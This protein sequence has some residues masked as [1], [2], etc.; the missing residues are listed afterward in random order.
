[1][2]HPCLATLCVLLVFVVG[3][4]CV[5]SQT[6]TVELQ[7][8]DKDG[9]IGQLLAQQLPREHFSK[10]PFDETI[11]KRAFD[12]YLKSL[13]PQ[14]YYF[15]QS[16]IDEFK[17]DETEI[18]NQLTSG[19]VDLGFEIYNRFVQRFDERTMMVGE[20]LKSPLDLS[21]HEE[22]IIDKNLLTYP[23]TKEEA[24]DRCRKKVKY[25]YLTLN[26]D[27]RDALEMKNGGTQT[28]STTEARIARLQRRNE[29]TKKRVHL[30]N[31]YDVLELYLSAVA[32]AYDPYSSYMPEDLF[33]STA[34]VWLDGIG[35]SL[36]LEDGIATI[37]QIITAGPA[38]KD[39]RLQI[40]DQI[41]GVGQ[42]SDSEINDVVDW[43]L[44]D[45]VQKI[46]GKRGTTVR[47]QVLPAYGPGLKIIELVRN[48]IKWEDSQANHAIFDVGTKD[49]DTTFRV[50]IID[51]PSFCMNM[52]AAE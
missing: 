30:A 10:H 42:G 48:E 1:M 25:D 16:D 41:L 39:G 18:C 35:V 31:N 11:S 52:R 32:G 15:Y 26:A 33:F 38:D 40:N 29:S 36:T 3:C 45:I 46:R 37:K 2:K 23:K 28:D 20:I 14:K 5:F 43:K 6:V 34:H 8:T 12:L 19:K 24:F 13:D 9:I 7:P 49:D 21:V 22:Y 50:G 44:K 47:L 4:G 17:K 27:N 51:L